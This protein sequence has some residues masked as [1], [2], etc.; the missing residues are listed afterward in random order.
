[1]SSQ[2]PS[3]N[4]A[5]SKRS[6]GVIFFIM[7]MDIV[8]LSILG[9]IAPFVVQR[10]SSDA[11]NVTL[12]T[13]IYAAAQFLAAPFLGKLSDR[14]GRRPVLV[15]SV[16]GSAFGYFLFGI[17][18]ALWVLFLSRLI[19]GITGGNLST[20]MAYIADVSAPEERAKNFILV[21]MSYGLGF[22]IGPALSSLLSPISVDAPMFAAAGLALLQAVAVIFFLPESLPLERRETGSL[23]F[24]D[25]N[26]LGAIGYMAR[27]PGLAWLFTVEALFNFAFNGVV[28]IL[29]IYIIQ[30]Y[31]VEPWQLG[32][33]FVVSGIANII[34]QS[35]LARYLTPKLGE[36]N[37]SI[38][39]LLGQAASNI[40]F[41]FTTSAG[42]LY[43]LSLLRQGVTSFIWGAL[44]ALIS[45][46]V[47]DREQGVLAGVNAALSSLM[48]V[49]GPLWAG[50]MYD[51][52][53]PESTMWFSAAL[54]ILAALMLA[55]VK[56]AAN[57]PI[58]A[59]QFT[60][61]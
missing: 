17:G 36:K 8:G 35:S 58:Q 61:A 5:A 41:V 24:S 33:F 44:G 30:K 26:P 2:S 32:L 45:N 22:V 57:N 7:L 27:K 11:L 28:A 54:L 48:A 39:S 16:I 56:T 52:V 43:P 37:L 60:E 29:G 3:Q 34:V 14:I 53:S 59:P 21:G 4:P 18:G 13:V 1:M 50:A 23:K 20:A 47:S 49:V 46:K 9:P 51:H 38:L 10:Y 55:R 42:W 40:A 12:L 25:L 31:G 6:L 19:D 15:W